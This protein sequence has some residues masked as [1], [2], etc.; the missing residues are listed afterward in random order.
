MLLHGGALE[1]W[2][3]EGKSKWVPDIQVALRGRER[4]VNCA[5]LM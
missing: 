5:F 4:L 2:I 1:A 3:N